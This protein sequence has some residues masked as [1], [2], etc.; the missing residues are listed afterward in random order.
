MKLQKKF[1]RKYKDKNYYKYVIHIPPHIVED[2]NLKE[3]EEL[4]VD[5]ENGKIVIKKL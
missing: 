1:I 5:S 3:G 2:L 4:E